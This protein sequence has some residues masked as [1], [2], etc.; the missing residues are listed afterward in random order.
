MQG[1]RDGNRIPEGHLFHA[2][3]PP[4]EQTTSATSAILRPNDLDYL[5]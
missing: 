2:V 5:P 3:S 4:P 1:R